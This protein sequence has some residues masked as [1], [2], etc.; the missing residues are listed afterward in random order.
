MTNQQ[1]AVLSL[2]ITLFYEDQGRHAEG[3]FSQYQSWEAA[4]FAV[5]NLWFSK[6]VEATN[7]GGLGDATCGCRNCQTS[8]RPLETYFVVCLKCGCKRCPKAIYHGYACTGSNAPY[9]VGVIDA[10]V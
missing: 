9:Q 2:A 4:P 6:A 7:H 3:D 8:Y 10:L 1:V 5:R